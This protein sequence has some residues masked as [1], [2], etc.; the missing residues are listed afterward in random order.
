MLSNIKHSIWKW[1]ILILLGVGLGIGITALCSRKSDPEEKIPPYDPHLAI[2]SNAQVWTLI[3]P[4]EFFLKYEEFRVILRF[5]DTREVVVMEGQTKQFRKGNCFLYLVPLPLGEGVNE[6]DRL[7]IRFASPGV[8]SVT[9]KNPF[10]GCRP[11]SFFY[12]VDLESGKIWLAA[13]SKTKI[14]W[15]DS[16]PE[17]PD[18][19]LFLLF[20]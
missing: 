18:A 3:I 15:K 13:G 12:E 17:D 14:T 20:E 10:R 19:A 2:I 9:E 16:I 4:E 6:C 1:M 5:P 8:T 7:G 11:I